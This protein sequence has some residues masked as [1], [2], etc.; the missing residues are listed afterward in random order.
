MVTSRCL[1]KLKGTGLALSSWGLRARKGNRHPL[2][3]HRLHQS[4]AI[5]SRPYPSSGTR[6]SLTGW[7]ASFDVAETYTPFDSGPTIVKPAQ[8][9]GETLAGGRPSPPRRDRNAKTSST[10]W[11]STISPRAASPP[12]APGWPSRSSPTTWR[13][14]APLEQLNQTLR[15]RFFSLTGRLSLTLHLR[16]GPG[17]IQS[18]LARFRALPLPS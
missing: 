12:T 14:T 6:P 18:A 2:L 17:R 11:G 9:A 10:A 8:L 3:H 16:A 4:C 7:K 1:P 13:W 15:R 5:S